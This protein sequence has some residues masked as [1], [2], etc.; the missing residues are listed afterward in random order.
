MAITVVRRLPRIE[1]PADVAAIDDVKPARGE[2][3]AESGD[4][5][6]LRPHRCAAMAG[7]DVGRRADQ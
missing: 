6:R 7:A 4:A 2:R 5:Q 1:R 3:R